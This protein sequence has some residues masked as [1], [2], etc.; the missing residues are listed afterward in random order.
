MAI[1]G[2]AIMRA[3]GLAAALALGACAGAG[4][5]DI[6]PAQTRIITPTEATSKCIGDISTP[7]CA[8]E[9]FLACMWRL[10]RPHCEQVGVFGFSLDN[11]AETA[12]YRILSV[13]ILRAKDIP[14]RLRHT[15]WMRPGNAKVN[16]VYLNVHAPECPPEGCP[17]DFHL[18]P[19]PSGWQISTWCLLC[20]D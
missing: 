1:R 7:L 5:D 6:D 16:I 3:G 19:T 4:M 12:R 10:E 9:T 11:K 17:A 14:D 18:K 13:R 20:Y 2:S 8:V 15:D